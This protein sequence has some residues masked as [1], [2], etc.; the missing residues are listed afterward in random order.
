MTRKLLWHTHDLRLHDHAVLANI[1][2]EDALLP[3]Y[4]FDPVQL[5]PIAYPAGVPTFTK[6]GALRLHFLVSH[7]RALR[8]A[9]QQRGQNL[10]L[11]IG[12]P[13]LVLPALAEYF[14][15]DEIWTPQEVTFEELQTQSRVRRA[16]QK[17]TSQ[18]I[19]LRT[20]SAALLVDA[21]NLPF[22]ISQLPRSFTA[23]RKQV[24]SQDCFLAPLPAPQALPP[25]L[26]PEGQA[27]LDVGDFPT[28]EH[29]GLRTPMPD[30]R[31]A[32]PFGGGEAAALEHVRHY[33]WGAQYLAAYKETRN[34]LVGANYSSKLSPWLAAGALSARQVYAEVRAFEAKV[35][36]NDST[37]WLVFELLWRD[38]FRLVAKQYGTAIFKQGGIQHRTLA[39]ANPSGAFEKWTQGQTDN[40]FVNA[41]MHE[42]RLTGY[43]SNR[44]RQNAASYLC[45]DLQVDWRW[46]AAW[47]EH[48]LLDY[49]PCSNWGN[50]MYIAGVGN[51]GPN[52]R[53]DVK[54]QA[55]F[56]DPQGEYQAL[57]NT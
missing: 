11:R 15:A 16:M 25:L 34:G 43:L 27:P 47:F 26:L 38:Y 35:V 19:P 17:L 54:R 8:E 13:A 28:L 48:C 6:A 21:K 4:C 49:D 24:E 2:L 18:R 23:F 22:P 29:F 30:L 1:T 42:L 31:T 41:C 9:Y 5:N 20:F 46:G 10:I 55:A 12:D 52:R 44:G 45:Y 56:Y 40:A 32:F 39:Y 51:G 7:L 36:A 53:F 14:S 33:I 37:Y 3:V 50:W 57:W